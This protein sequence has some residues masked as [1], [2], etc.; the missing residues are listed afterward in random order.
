M[1][2]RGVCEPLLPMSVRINRRLWLA[3]REERTNSALVFF[4]L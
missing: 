3:V 2:L 1:E 4:L